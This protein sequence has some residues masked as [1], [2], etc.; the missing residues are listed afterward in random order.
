MG[1]RLCGVCRAPHS[2]ESVRRAH[3]GSRE[4]SRGAVC[5]KVETSTPSPE[6]EVPRC[7]RRW[8]GLFHGDRRRSETSFSFPANPGFLWKLFFSC[9]K[10][11]SGPKELLFKPGGPE[12]ERS[13]GKQDLPEWERFLRRKSHSKAPTLRTARYHDHWINSRAIWP[14]VPA[15]A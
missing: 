14:Q 7:G 15:G 8:A 9:P 12:K 13:K 6:D 11:L 10:A 5:P 2:A 3:R 1:G 4:R